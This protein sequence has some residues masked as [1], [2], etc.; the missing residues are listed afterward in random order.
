[1]NNKIYRK[2]SINTPEILPRIHNA[3]FDVKWNESFIMQ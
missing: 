1:M 2:K 3:N